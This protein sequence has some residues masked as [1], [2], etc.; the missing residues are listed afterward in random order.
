MQGSLKF[1]GISSDDLQFKMIV[2]QPVVRFPKRKVTSTNVSGMN[3][4]RYDF[5]DAWEEKIIEYK[6]LAG[7]EEATNYETFVEIMEWLNSADDY[8]VL[9]D[10]FDPNHY[11]LAVCIDGADAIMDLQHY[12][13]TTLRFRCRPERYL[14]E[15]VEILPPNQSV[16]VNDTNH[17]AKPL[18]HLTGTNA[19]N[20]MQTIYGRIS[21]TVTA[22][23]LDTLPKNPQSRLFKAVG[24]DL[25]HEGRIPADPNGVT[26]SSST[27]TAFTYTALYSFGVGFPAIVRP[28]TKYTLSYNVSNNNHG[29]IDTAIFCF[30]RFN[31]YLGKSFVNHS[32]YNTSQS[33]TFTTPSD[34]EMIMLLVTGDADTYVLSNV[35]LAYG[36]EPLPYSEWHNPHDYYD[37]PFIGMNGIKL[38]INE[39]FLECDIDC[40]NEDVYLEGVLSN[41]VVSVTENGEITPKFINLKSGNNNITLSTQITGGTIEKRLWEL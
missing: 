15:D 1:N 35:M 26:S 9:T 14:I 7:T 30:D 8:A 20:H 3:G 19:A 27:T 21:T 41:T 5:E 32:A 36:S 40:E 24:L 18:I 13:K 2:D 33:I 4:N 11:H 23:Y 16:I 38:T 6:I 39:D 29:M 31:R 22:G 17:T 37:A 28:D 34:C 10:S 12:G 25:M